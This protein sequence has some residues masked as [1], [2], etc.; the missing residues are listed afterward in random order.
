LGK[1]LVSRVAT[2]IRFKHLILTKN[3]YKAYKEIRI[4]GLVKEKNYCKISIRKISLTRKYLKTNYI[5]DIQTP[6]IR[7]GREKIYEQHGTRIKQIV[8]ESMSVGEIYD[9]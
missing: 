9:N 1:D 3:N 5:E 7:C 2:I 4:Q 6:K 8:T